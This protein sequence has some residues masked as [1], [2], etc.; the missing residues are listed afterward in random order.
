MLS[1]TELPWQVQGCIDH[2]RGH[3]EVKVIGGPPLSEEEAKTYPKSAQLLQK[4]YGVKLNVVVGVWSEVVCYS[5]LTGNSVAHQVFLNKYSQSG[6]YQGMLPACWSGVNDDM[7]DKDG[8]LPTTLS[9]RLVLGVVSLFFIP[10]SG[11]F[12]VAPYYA[13]L[14]LGG[15]PHGLAE[16]TVH[17]ALAEMFLTLFLLGCIGLIWAVGMPQ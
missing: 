2:T 5:T 8:L 15:I 10:F 9:G 7:S 13:M 6:Y 16:W 17:V 14:I 1:N 11:V 3:C 4:L 12:V